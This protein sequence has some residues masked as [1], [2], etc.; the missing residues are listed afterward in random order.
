MRW[1]VLCFFV[2]PLSCWGQEST[3]PL[4]SSEDILHLNLKFDVI[5]TI[6]DRL[7][8]DEHDAILYYDENSVLD[9]LDVKL[10]VRGM[11]RA[12]PK[13]CKFPPLRVNFKK[14]QVKGTLFNGLDKIKLV[15]HCNER[16]INE[17]YILREYYVYKLYQLVSPFSF[18]VRLCKISYIDTAGKYEPEEH[19]AFFIE[20]IDDLAERNSM[21]EYKSKIINQDVCSREDIDRLTVFQFLIGN[22]D[23]SIPNEHNFKLIYGGDKPVPVAVPYDFDYSGLVNTN[24]AKPPPEIDVNSVRERNFRGF[25]RDPGEYEEVAKLFQ[26]LKPA[27]YALYT[28][29][30]HLNEKSKDQSIKYIDSFYK[31]LDNPKKF[32][33]HIIRGCRVEHSHTYSH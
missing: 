17:Q 2:L 13:V 31:I 11:T 12:N 32:E 25:C 19:F 9:S 1:L 4:F 10:M 30:R 20:D 29:S 23:W 15:T 18:K 3:L 7:E 24:Y 14:K 22:L 21:Q 27:I 28:N 33:S 8:R 5:E 26:E 6:D 16:E